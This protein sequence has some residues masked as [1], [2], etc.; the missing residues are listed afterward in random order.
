MALAR[1]PH[2]A[3]VVL[4]L[5]SQADQVRTLRTVARLP[6]QESAVRY[7]LQPVVTTPMLKAL[8]DRTPRKLSTV[9]LLVGHGPTPKHNNPDVIV[10][11]LAS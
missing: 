6:T 8:K 4:R 11:P 5:L 3:H 7:Q 2:D 9:V 10:P 1:K